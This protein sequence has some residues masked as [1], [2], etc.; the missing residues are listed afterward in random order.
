[1]FS[2]SDEDHSTSDHTKLKGE[3][4]ARTLVTADRRHTPPATGRDT[5]HDAGR[6]GGRSGGGHLDGPRELSVVYF[7]PEP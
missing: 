1:M 5:R 3:R 2:K 7:M 4:A 6:S